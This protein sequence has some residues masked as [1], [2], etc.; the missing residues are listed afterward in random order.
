M[1][2]FKM[3][4]KLTLIIETLVTKPFNTGNVWCRGRRAA[5]KGGAGVLCH[6][7]FMNGDKFATFVLLAVDSGCVLLLV[8]GCCCADFFFL[9][10][11]WFSF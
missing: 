3:R 1:T 9:F 6:L 2:G 5:I 4:D 7:L 10:I 8:V 11:L